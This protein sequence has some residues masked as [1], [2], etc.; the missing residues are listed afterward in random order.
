MSRFWESAKRLVFSEKREN[1]KD[2]FSQDPFGVR[3]GT[4]HSA[5][6]LLHCS[7]QRSI[8]LL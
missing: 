4:A 1:E 8:I 7:Y 6:L 2:P 3:A 5:L